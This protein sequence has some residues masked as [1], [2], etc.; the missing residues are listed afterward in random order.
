MKSQGLWCLYTGISANFVLC[1]NPAIKHAVFD[2]VKARLLL[3]TGGKKRLS[4]LQSFV[5]GATA[6]MIASTLTFPAARTRAI[7]Q[8][9]RVSGGETKRLRAG[10]VMLAILANEGWAGLF[11]GLGPQLMKG[12]LSSALM[13]ATKE[14]LH[15]YAAIAVH[16]TIAFLQLCVANG[17]NHLRAGVQRRRRVG[18]T[19]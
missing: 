18:P 11:K 9:Q 14:K 6:T 15:K 12:V 3:L 13:L 16:V 8:T 19:K 2:Q 1:L 17:A 4:S 7:M 5:L 10:D